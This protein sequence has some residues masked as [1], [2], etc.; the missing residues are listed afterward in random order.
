[1]KQKKNSQMEMLQER[2][3]SKLSNLAMGKNEQSNAQGGQQ[4][5]SFTINW[6][7]WFDGSLFDKYK[8]KDGRRF[9]E[10]DRK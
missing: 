7:G 5:I 4:G 9:N 6:D 10:F 1:M 2:S 8:A 3:I